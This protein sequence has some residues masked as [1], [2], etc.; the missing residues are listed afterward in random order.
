MT[1]RIRSK[2]AFQHPR[3][4]TA[5]RAYPHS[6]LKERLKM[7]TTGIFEDDFF[8]KVQ[9]KG[10]GTSS[11]NLKNENVCS[12]SRHEG[13]DAHFNVMTSSRRGAR[14]TSDP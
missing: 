13:D 3:I 9:D 8:F 12:R 10:T 7:L 4:N 11:P 6:Q 1:V 2:H 14:P 5:Y